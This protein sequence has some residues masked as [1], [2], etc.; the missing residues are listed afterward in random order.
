M[1]TFGAGENLGADKE[2][3]IKV[4]SSHKMDRT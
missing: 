2:K 4:M 1:G 3:T